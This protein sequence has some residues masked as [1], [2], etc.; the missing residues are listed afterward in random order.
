MPEVLPGGQRQCTWTDR[1][2]GEQESESC[3]DIARLQRAQ[4]KD[5]GVCHEIRLA[6]RSNENDR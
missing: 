5:R 1:I 6:R 3:C 4:R 2:G